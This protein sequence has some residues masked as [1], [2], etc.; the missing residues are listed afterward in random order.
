MNQEVLST[1]RNPF[2]PLPCIFKSLLYNPLFSDFTLFLPNAPPGKKQYIPVHRFIFDVR[3]S[4]FHVF[5]ERMPN[6]KTLTLCFPQ[7][8]APDVFT[9]IEYIYTSEPINITNENIAAI[10]FIS[11]IWDCSELIKLATDFIIH[12]IDPKYSLDTLNKLCNIIKHDAPAIQKLLNMVVNNIAI[13]NPDDFNELQFDLFESIIN[14]VYSKRPEDI[15]AEALCNCIEHY[16]IANVDKLGKDEFRVLVQRFMMKTYHNGVITLYKHAI[17]LNWSIAHCEAKILHSWLH[18]DQNKLA[19]IPVDRLAVI[20]NENYLNC[21]SEDELFKFILLV[22]EVQP[23]A[24]LTPIWKCLRVPALT[25]E[26][27]EKLKECGIAPQFV[28]DAINS[29]GRYI[30]FRR[31]PRARTHCLIIGAADNWA[32][33][34]LKEFMGFAGFNPKNITAMRAAPDMDADFYKFHAIL[35]FGFYKFPPSLSSKIATYVSDGGGLVVAFGAHRNDDFG[36]GEPILSMLP[37]E[38]FRQEIAEVCYVRAPTDSN[39]N[40]GVDIASEEKEQIFTGCKNMRM[41]FSVKEGAS[42]ISSWDDGVP[43]V[44]IQN[45]TEKHGTI[46]VFNASPVS[47]EIFPEQWSKHDKTMARILSNCIITASNK[48]FSKA[49][50]D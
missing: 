40:D 5:F 3:C 18:L 38:A 28:I 37:I 39:F 6:E 21:G 14:T 2:K 26:C 50:K 41:L 1:D 46:I 9:V 33:E 22:H 42:V 4:F 47:N 44:V 20:L 48:V 11:L 43:F 12:K 35:V 8:A 45:R 23:T 29:A 49:S 17:R 31:L 10:A 34:D 16:F 7:W 19:T 25:E 15:A 13:F 32:L 36:I 30:D 27:K 24:D